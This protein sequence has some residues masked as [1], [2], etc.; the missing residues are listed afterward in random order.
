MATPQP[1]PAAEAEKKPIVKGG[2]QRFPHRTTFTPKKPAF[3][4]PTQGLGHI[5]F[6]NMG[7][8]K[9]VSTFN[10][11]IEAISE[12]LTNCHK[13]DRPLTALAVHELKKATIEFTSDPSDMATLIKMTKWQRKYNHAYDQQK[14]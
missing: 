2:Q 5:I 4:A 8:A 11:N 12:H 6:D 1:P 10:L 3:A 7:T 13:Y 14:W 9:V